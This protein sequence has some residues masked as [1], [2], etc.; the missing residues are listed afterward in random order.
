[1][2]P[3]RLIVLLLVSA[4]LVPSARAQ[5]RPSEK[6]FKGVEL[7]SWQDSNGDWLFVLL[8]GTNR[9]KSEAEVKQKENRI[10]GTNELEKHFLRLAEGEQVFWSH[11]ELEGFAYPDEETMKAIA[12]S[13]RK[14]KVELHVPRTAES[15][16]GTLRQISFAGPEKGTSRQRSLHRDG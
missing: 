9:L 7:Y 10:V 14:A 2:K 4:L 6:E 16:T 5:E 15:P 1:M 11:R 12:S 13:A 3:T 8:P